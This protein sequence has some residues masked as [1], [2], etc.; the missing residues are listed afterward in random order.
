MSIPVEAKRLNLTGVL[1]FPAVSQASNPVV[2]LLVR[3]EVSS[4]N[5]S[6]KGRPRIAKF[7]MIIIISIYLSI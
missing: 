6:R 7:Y 3:H 4:L 5:N 1:L 2:H